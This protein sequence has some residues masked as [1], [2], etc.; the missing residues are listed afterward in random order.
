[1]MDQWSKTGSTLK[2]DNSDTR[3]EGATSS[4]KMTQDVQLRR[5]TRKYCDEHLYV[6]VVKM[7]RDHNVFSVLKY[8]PMKV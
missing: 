5:K 3:G 2:R 7:N 4:S 6:E 8:C 1:M